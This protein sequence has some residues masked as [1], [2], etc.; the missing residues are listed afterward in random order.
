MFCRNNFKELITKIEKEQLFVVIYFWYSC[1]FGMT[2]E[3]LIPESN[4]LIE[5]KAKPNLLV[6]LFSLV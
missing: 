3:K 5:T 2:L 6:N 1:K 4:N